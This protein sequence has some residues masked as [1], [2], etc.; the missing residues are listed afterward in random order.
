MESNRKSFT[1]VLGLILHSVQL[2]FRHRCLSSK[3]ML[4]PYEIAHRRQRHDSPCIK[5]GVCGFQVLNS[6]ISSTCLSC[7]GQTILR[8]GFP[9]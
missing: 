1:V 2:K 7:I 6:L 4:V 5:L 3:G 8:I 9:N